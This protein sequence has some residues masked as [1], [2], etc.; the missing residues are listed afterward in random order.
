ME[1]STNILDMVKG[2]NGI[3]V[4]DYQR[5]YSWERDKQVYV[6]IKDLEEYIQSGSETPYYFG[7]FLYEKM[8]E[9]KRFGIIDGQ[10]RMTTI[11]IFLC[12]IFER[13]KRE[14]AL[15]EFEENC[16]EDMIKRRSSYKFKTVQYDNQL[17]QD[18]IINHLPIDK[19]NLE[20]LSAKRIIEAYDYFYEYLT[21]KSLK[22]VEILLEKVT[23]ASCTTHIVNNEAEAIQMFIFQNDRG[24]K[25]SNMEII[26]A[27]FM[28]AIHLK[29]GEDR[30]DLLVEI[31]N[32]FEKIYRCISKLE[33]FNV[34]EDG[35]LNIAAKLYKNTLYNVDVKNEIE[36]ELKKVS[37]IDFVVNFTRNL[38]LTFNNLER[39]FQ[40]SKED[41]NIEYSLCLDKHDIILPFFV[42]AYL[43]NIEI[44]EIKR[45][46]KSL[47][48]IVLRNKIIQ[49]RAD[50]HSRLNDVFKEME[51]SVENVIKRIDYLKKPDH[52]WWGYWSDDNVRATA[53][54][55]NWGTN[56][57]RLAKIILWQYEN[58]LISTKGKSGYKPIS[59][60]SIENPHLEHIAPQT[61]NGSVAS[62]YDEYDEEFRTQCLLSLG[63]FLLL[64]SSHNES[65]GNIP[66]EDKRKTYT[67]LEQQ[68]EIIDM[69]PDIYW[70]RK[71][72]KERTNK[73]VSFIVNNL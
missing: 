70:D 61:E 9:G 52:W 33:V 49:T 48:D 58:F 21:G 47:G 50:L 45:M 1:A 39:L 44:A 11:T 59:Y 19:N 20:T 51:K 66:F 42:K 65:I 63:N 64:S 67:K 29:G 18:Y 12:A 54:D 17:F 62:G 27:Q 6:F 38:E 23:S 55:S 57:H 15:T 16:I 56:Y 13:I 73:I 41:V 37:P 36:E 30:D 40:D 71:K 26:K 10:Q 72:I 8:E 32:R 46:A 60:H 5:A 43:H 2:A 3:S 25:P 31:K 34:E 28:F 69:T 7:H 4:P 14:R 22:E 53:S 35:V 24:K 68:R